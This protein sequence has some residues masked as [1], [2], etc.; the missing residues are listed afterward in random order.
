MPTAEE[1]LEEAVK[2]KDHFEKNWI[3]PWHETRGPGSIWH[4][5]L[6]HLLA[7]LPDDLFDEV[8]DGLLRQGSFALR[9][10]GLHLVRVRG[11]EPFSPLVRELCQDSSLHVRALAAAAVGQFNDSEGLDVLLETKDGENPEVKKAVVDAMKRIR[12]PRCIPLLARWVGRVGEDDDLRH[13]ACEAL[14]DI[15]DEAAMPVLMRVI[16]DETAADDVR[17][18]AA[19][20]IGLIAGPEA[21][22]VLLRNLSHQR[23]WIRARSAE[24]L[25]LLGDRQSLERLLPLLESSNP[26]MVRTHAIGAVAR[27][28]G[29]GAL[30]H[31]TPLLK[32]PELRIRSETAAALA[33]VDSPQAR[34]LL[35]GM[36]DDPEL[37][38]RVAA[39]GAFARVTGEDFGFRLEDHQGAL[40]PS[41]LEKALRAARSWR[42]AS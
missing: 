29:Q 7:R 42:P 11:K 1:I 8:M 28:G 10:L 15:G 26:W 5:R 35:Q 20:A 32:D 31:L 17:G 2:L 24:G 38:V 19:R 12:D 21:K 37:P 36:L 27:L 33:L 40:D 14:A 23:P 4:H 13:K 18:E 25:G 39:L 30:K 22:E 9:G 3:L 6:V 41:A 34:D 16:E